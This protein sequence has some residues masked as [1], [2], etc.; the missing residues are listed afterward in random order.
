MH[1]VQSQVEIAF[2]RRFLRSQ[3]VQ[4]SKVSESLF[5]PISRFKSALLTLDRERE[6]PH[7]LGLKLSLF[8]AS[9]LDFLAFYETNGANFL[10]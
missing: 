4:S 1:K 7:F 8:L 10:C 3:K 5:D 9:S 2:L 6:N